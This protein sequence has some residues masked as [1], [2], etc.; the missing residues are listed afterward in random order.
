M[1]GCYCQQLRVITPH[2]PGLLPGL[3][4]TA[5]LGYNFGIS[6]HSLTTVSDGYNHPDDGPL[7][8]SYVYSYNIILSL[9]GSL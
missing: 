3:Y 8:L 2:T 5:A 7:P 4:H 6:Q 1:P 9:P